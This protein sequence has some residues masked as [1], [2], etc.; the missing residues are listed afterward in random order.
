MERIGKL[1]FEFSQNLF[2]SKFS[3]NEMVEILS[4]TNCIYF[5]DK[6]KRTCA[7]PKKVTHYSIV[8][9]KEVIKKLTANF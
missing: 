9:K 2:D 4:G 7:N 5:Y 8:D 6:D 3:I 1:F